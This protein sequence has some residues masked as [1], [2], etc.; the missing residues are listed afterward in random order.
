M[1]YYGARAQGRQ[2]RIAANA[3]ARRMIKEPLRD[4]D[5]STR[6]SGLKRI[7]AHFRKRGQAR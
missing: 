6:P 2:E 7:L 4:H 3:A 5:D 1:N